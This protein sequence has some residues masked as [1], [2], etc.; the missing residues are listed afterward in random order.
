LNNGN[1]NPADIATDQVQASDPGE[2]Q[3]VDQKW[4]V[5]PM[6]AVLGAVACI[7]GSLTVYHQYFA[8]RQVKFALL[9][10]HHI[11]DAKEIEFTS[12][13]AKPNVTDDDR[14]RAMD[15]VAGIEPQLKQVLAQVRSECGCEILVKAA[16]LTSDNIPDITSRVAELMK[17]NDQD[18]AKAREA[19]RR[20]I[21]GA[22]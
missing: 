17:I 11:V 15:M 9:D 16:A 20:N 21:T 1:S 7:V 10:L 14:K 2:V 12:M 6:W 18:L 22:K 13:L 4:W 3:S 19:I 8:P 5:T